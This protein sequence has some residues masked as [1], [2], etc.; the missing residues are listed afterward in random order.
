MVFAVAVAV[1][2]L[3]LLGSWS[4]SVRIITLLQASAVGGLVCA[5]VSA[6]IQW[7]LTRAV[8]GASSRSLPDVV[9][10]ASWS[11]DAVV[12]EIVK[13]APLLLLAWIWPKVHRQLGWT[14]HLSIGVALGMGF[15]LCEAALRY[16]RLGPQTM[17][18]GRIRG[19]PWA[20]YADRRAVRRH[21]IDI[22]AAR[23]GVLRR[24][25]FLR[26]RLNWAPRVDGIDGARRGVGNAA[27][28][29]DPTSRDDTAGAG[30]PITCRAQR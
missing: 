19:Q 26:E 10:I 12:E 5:P 21:I 25:V 22:V 2:Q 13:I 4:R 9:A 28:R 29:L 30:L 8:A 1:T 18:T 7:A 17:D 27:T 24:L 16:G 20:A 6:A 11:Y 14:D 15:A 3:G 23:A